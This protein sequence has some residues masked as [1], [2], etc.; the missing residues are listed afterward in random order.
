MRARTPSLLLG[1]GLLLGA[2]LAGAQGELKIPYE[3]YT[4][5]NGL[6]VILSEDHRLPTVVVDVW[7][8][9]GAVNE[10]PGK[11]GFAHLFEHIMFQGS[12]HVAEDTFFLY[13]QSAGSSNVNGTTNNDRT[14]YFEQLPANQLELA[15]WLESDRMGFLLDTLSKERLD[16]QRDVVRNERRQRRDNV[17]YGL[18]HEKLLHAIFPKEHPYYGDVIG[19]H[20]DLQAASLDDVR[21]FFKSY[22]H[23]GNATL[24]IV[25]DFNPK[26]AKALVEKYFGPVAKGPAVTKP[27]LT[28][29]KITAEKKLPPMPDKV[30]LPRIYYAWVSPAFFQPGDAEAD[31]LTRVL[32]GGKSSRLYKRMVYD[33]K[34]AQDV[35]ASQL[36]MGEV[37]LFIIE[38]TAK[39]GT[40]VDQLGKEIDEE[41]DKLRKEL[42]PEEELAR[43]RRGFEVDTFK[44]LEGTLS[45]AEFLQR[46]N[47]YLGDPGKIAW[48]VGRY[49]KLGAKDVQKFVNDYLSPSARVVLVVEP[50][51]K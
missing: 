19:S 27:K 48:D 38:A 9:V 30:T 18:A 25:G 51:K 5:P 26:D 4:L 44:S 11:S 49:G 22:Y 32:S 47:H 28:I 2:R 33:E 10:V 15:L 23:P 36:S 21:A 46:Y 20:E 39:P 29:P 34:I 41:L 12:K 17:P 24:T 40:S 31:L 1:L 16:G 50:E 43:A 6:E 42:V 7:Y 45:K 35:N 37:S 3:K 8:H 13:L 14:N